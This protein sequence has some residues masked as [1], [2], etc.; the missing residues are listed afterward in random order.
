M[1]TTALPQQ[2]N[3]Q[4][5]YGKVISC[6]SVSKTSKEVI[7]PLSQSLFLWLSHT[8]NQKRD[9]PRHHITSPQPCLI[10]TLTLTPLPL[11]ESFTEMLSFHYQV[12]STIS[13][14]AQVAILRAESFISGRCPWNPSSHGS[15]FLHDERKLIGVI[16]YYHVSFLLLEEETHVY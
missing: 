14:L 8:E 9:L 12:D 13:Y 10:P 15:S 5:T 7:R 11:E 2:T 6:H 4:L 16:S 1:F 3:R